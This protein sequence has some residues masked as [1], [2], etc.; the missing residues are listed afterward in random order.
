MSIK[1]LVLIA[2]VLPALLMM[3]CRKSSEKAAETGA[4]VIYT[5]DAFSEALQE[6]LEEHFKAILNVTVRLERWEDTGGLYNQVYLER[7]NP[8]ADVVIGLDNTYL[9][10]IFTDE[11]FI[12][13]KPQGLML[14]SEGLLVDPEYRAVAF[15][16]GGVCLNYDSEVLPS[17]PTTW[18]ELLDGSLKEKIIL[19]NPATSSPGRSFL[20]F[21]IA[22]FGEDGYLDFWRKLKPNLLTVTSGWSEGYGLYTQG[23]APIILSYDTS[24]AYHRHFESETKYKNLIFEGKAYAQVEVAGIVKGAPNLK[25][26]QACMDYI[27][28]PEF[29]TLIPLNQIMYPVHPDVELPDAFV[30][31]ERALNFVNLNEEDV[32]KKLDRW[33]TDWEAVMR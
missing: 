12:P 22:V 9:A 27:V 21:T 26:A 6:S 8:K 13:Y 23:E 15:D 19:M 10:R 24:P 7:G 31:V 28:S 3:G 25:N 33:L 16:Y 5:Y 30:D 29:Q 17:P 18:D 1:R 32:A 14:V 20:L 2:A 4:L 11:L